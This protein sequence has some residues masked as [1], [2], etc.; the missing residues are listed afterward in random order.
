MDHTINVQL[1]FQHDDP[2]AAKV[3]AD[4][5]AK[6]IA[7]LKAEQAAKGVTLYSEHV[8]LRSAHYIRLPGE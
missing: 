7:D 4:K 5:V 1:T 6:A 3:I 8:S 2:I